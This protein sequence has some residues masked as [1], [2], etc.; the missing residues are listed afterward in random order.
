[1]SAVWKLGDMEF[2]LGEYQEQAILVAIVYSTLDV[3][4]AAV[5]HT[6]FHSLHAP[7]DDTGRFGELGRSSGGRDTGVVYCQRVVADRIHGEGQWSVGKWASVFL[8]IQGLE[9]G[10][11]AV[12]GRE[13]P[14]HL[15]TRKRLLELAVV[16]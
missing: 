9:V 8:G 14:V 5:V 15:S 3:L 2:D 6:Q 12:E 7:A 10:C 13:P 1:M 11:S 4:E 16:R